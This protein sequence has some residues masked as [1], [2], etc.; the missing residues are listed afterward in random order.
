MSKCIQTLSEVTRKILGIPTNK[1]TKKMIGSTPTFLKDRWRSTSPA[2]MSDR[3]LYISRIKV[4]T[5][6]YKW[7]LNKLSGKTSEE[8]EF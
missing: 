8:K 2:K 4:S 1:F 3:N 5:R 7:D 6:I